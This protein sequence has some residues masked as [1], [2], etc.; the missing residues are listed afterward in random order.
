MAAPSAAAR[1]QGPEG[2]RGSSGTR[3][4]VGRAIRFSEPVHGESSDPTPW[5]ASRVQKGGSRHKFIA[6]PSG[7]DKGE[8]GPRTSTLKKRPP[9]LASFGASSR[10]S[11]RR[12]IGWARGASD[13]RPIDRGSS[14]ELDGT[15][16]DTARRCG[17]HRHEPSSAP[18]VLDDFR[19]SINPILSTDTTIRSAIYDESAHAASSQSLN[20]GA[21]ESFPFGPFDKATGD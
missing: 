21:D 12:K 18:S 6:R 4:R 1:S 3:G 8:D 13:E 7:I 19:L 11:A 10:K 16:H 5:S 17:V 14:L 20:G 9:R 2:S 15:V